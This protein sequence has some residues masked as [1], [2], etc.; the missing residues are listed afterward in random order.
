M[1]MPPNSPNSPGSP[2]AD[3]PDGPEGYDARE[4]PPRAVTVDIAVFTV[5]D[6]RLHVLMLERGPD[7]PWFP[8]KFALPGS[9]VGDDE[10]LQQAAV[11]VLWEKVGLDLPMHT[12]EQFGAYGD[13]DRD[14]RMRVISIGFMGL[15]ASTMIEDL[16]A[17]SVLPPE[18]EFERQR[19]WM[20]VDDLIDSEVAMVAFD[21]LRILEEARDR[22][23]VRV[24]ETDA[25]LELLPEPFTL[26]QLRE[27]YEA[28]WGMTIDPGNFAKR[29]GRVEGFIEPIDSAVYVSTLESP[30]MSMSEPLMETHDDVQSS[31]VEL[32]RSVQPM[33]SLM[34]SSI[35]KSSIPK[36]SVEE[37]SSPSRPRGRPPK[38]FIRGGN[39]Q[40]HP[41]I[42]RPGSYF[43]K[44]PSAS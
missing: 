26:A 11:R 9:F 7:E 8:G 19:C 29:V 39:E 16:D 14:P 35:P 28:I 37:S 42:R 23:R 27:V 31:P 10:N 4:F 25:A 32:M 24:E 38:W 21:H 30:M 17:G 3:G 36:S 15:I 2:L 6:G 40:L 44:P 13:P 41:P 22:L 18:L 12:L 34:M 20:A 5:T 33:R 1:T 43:S